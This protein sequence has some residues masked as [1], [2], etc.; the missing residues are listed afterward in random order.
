MGSLINLSGFTYGITSD[1]V[2]INIRELQV[3]SSLEYNT[4]VTNHSGDI[5][6][7]AIGLSMAE[8]TV[9]GETTANNGIVAAVAGTAYSLANSVDQFG[10]TVGGC[11]AVSMRITGNRD[12][13]KEFEVTF[14]R[15]QGIT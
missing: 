7:K 9:S 10:Q 8:I 15:I 3:N 5:R 4:K 12:A 2:A 6:G 11:Y 14:E 1:E 13:L